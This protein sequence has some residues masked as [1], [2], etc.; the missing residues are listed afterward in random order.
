MA[1]STMRWRASASRP[2]VSASWACAASWR[3]PT[4]S[5]RPWASCSAACTGTAWRSRSATLALRSSR[6]AL[7]A[8]SWSRR[9]PSSAETS[10]SWSVRAWIWRASGLG[11]AF[12]GLGLAATAGPAVK[13]TATTANRAQPAL[14]TRVTTTTLATGR[15]GT[16]AEIGRIEAGAYLDVEEPRHRDGGAEGADDH[17]DDDQE[18]AGADHLVGAHR[19]LVEELDVANGMLGEVA[20]HVDDAEGGGCADEPLDETLE[21]ERDAD[22][23]VGGAHQLHHRHLPA[24]GVD[25]HTDGVEDQKGG[26]AQQHDGHG[27]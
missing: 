15:G 13:A 4:S 18:D 17:A 16:T 8:C 12:G 9:A 11:G 7:D 3:A 20:H 5:S 27:P 10:S 6:R 2:W 22:E 19:E 24:S 1:R 14:P 21:H 23:P 25:R 26:R